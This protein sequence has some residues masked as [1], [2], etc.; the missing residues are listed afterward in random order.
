MKILIIPFF[1]G[2]LFTSCSKNNSDVP[3]PEPGTSASRIKT[4]T[5]SYV[6]TYFYNAEGK[7]TKYENSDGSGSA[8]EYQPGIVIRKVYN[9]AGVFQ[10]SY[11]HELNADA[12]VFRTT[13]SNN[14]AYEIIRLY[15]ADKSIAKQISMINGN[16]NSIDYFYSNG[17]CDSMRFTGNNGNWSSTVVKTYYT[18]KPNVLTDAATGDDFY[19]KASKDMLKSEIYKYPDGSS[20][21]LATYTYEYDGQGRVIK[22]TRSQ[23]GNINISLITYY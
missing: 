23:G 9:T 15:N 6:T 13:I 4:R 20:N 21:E 18:G 5:S 17:N 19:G 22:E 8:F 1:A 3:S 12:L 7:A 10:Y 11:K 14:P 16:N 2:V